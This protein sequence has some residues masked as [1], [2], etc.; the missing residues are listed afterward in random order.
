MAQL[1][2]DE[3][4]LPRDSGE[5]TSQPEDR[6]ESP[7]GSPKQANKDQ[8]GLPAASNGSPAAQ[9]GTG[10]TDSSTENGMGFIN[11]FDPQML[12]T[13]SF[14]VSVTREPT[15]PAAQPQQ[16]TTGSNGESK[17]PPPQDGAG[18]TSQSGNMDFM[19][20]LDRDSLERL[21]FLRPD[22]K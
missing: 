9:D 2:H 5:L 1:F 21:G 15:A 11:R 4:P 13:L 22:S 3:Q 20:P 8:N 14:A 10:S 18:S 16:P 17:Q 12:P 6:R 19:Q 7:M